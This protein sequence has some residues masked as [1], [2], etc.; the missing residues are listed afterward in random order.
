MGNPNDNFSVKDHTNSI[1]Y[2]DNK[3]AKDW[4]GVMALIAVM[5]PVTE[6]QAF[7]AHKQPRKGCPSKE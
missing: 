6:N 3:T 4:L 1:G 5:E 7:R 2:N